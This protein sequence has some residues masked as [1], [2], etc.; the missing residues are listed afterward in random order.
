MP[1]DKVYELADQ[2]N[3]PRHFELA[4]FFNDPDKDGRLRDVMQS[5]LPPLY[6]AHLTFHL[7]AHKW[8]F[9]AHSVTCNPTTQQLTFTNVLSKLLQTHSKINIL[10]TGTNLVLI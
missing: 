4:I 5:S 8:N 10:F 7:S 6:A 3:L 2:R 1:I 9:N